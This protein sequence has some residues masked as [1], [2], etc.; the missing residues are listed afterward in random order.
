MLSGGRFVAKAVIPG[1][2][3]IYVEIGSRFNPEDKRERELGYVPIRIDSGDVEGV[4]VTTT[5]LAKVAGRVVFEDGAPEK[6]ETM[7]VSAAV[8]ATTVRAMSVG[9]WPS[10]EVG[11]D[12]TFELTGLFGPQ[13][14]AV[15]GLPPGWVVRSVE[16]RDEDVTDLPV[17]FKTS[18]DPAA[19]EITLTRRGAVVSGR[20]LDAAGKGTS[21]GYILLISADPARRRS[22]VGL[23]KTARPKSDGAFTLGAVRAGEY[24]IVASTGEFLA[25]APFPDADALERVAQAGE[26]LVLVESEKR[27]I[28]LRVV[29]PQ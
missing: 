20:V 16:Y 5:R 4:V 6:R 11:S 29:K 18:T 24:I 14:I 21:A 9:P 23:V 19:L 17:E 25:Y 8:T 13:T 27:E 28:D 26:R 15:T 2:Y 1:D 3:A 12:S 10:A 7:R 22:G